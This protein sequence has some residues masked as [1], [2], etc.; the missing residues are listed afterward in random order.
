MLLTSGYTVN[1][2]GAWGPS[3]NLMGTDAFSSTKETSDS[4]YLFESL[5]GFAQSLSQITPYEQVREKLDEYTSYGTE[6]LYIASGKLDSY[7][8]KYTKYDHSSFFVTL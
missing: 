6:C 8:H 1:M 3:V 4:T 2:V 5:F 7:H